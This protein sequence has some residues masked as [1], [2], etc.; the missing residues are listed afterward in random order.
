MAEILTH[1]QEYQAVRG[2]IQQLTTTGKSRV[3]VSVDGI[4]VS[5]Q[6]AQLSLLQ[7]REIE[8]ARRLSCR[9]TRKRTFA[10]F[11]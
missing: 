6:A 11:S 9:N 8:L 3:S 4:T 1:A 5:Y 10:E 2:A 7:A